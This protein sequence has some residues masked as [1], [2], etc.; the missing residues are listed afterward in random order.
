MHEPTV[1]PHT[2]APACVRARTHPVT[3]LDRQIASHNS[4]IDESTETI[5]SV[6]TSLLRIFKTIGCDENLIAGCS[7]AV[8]NF[9]SSLDELKI[10][11]VIFSGV[12]EPARQQ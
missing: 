6:K 7:D 8:C 3:A 4:A 9:T 10:T 1:K 5:E 11:T 2:H 12:S